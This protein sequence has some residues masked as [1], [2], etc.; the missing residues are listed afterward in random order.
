MWSPIH[1]NCRAF[2]SFLYS[3][4]APLLP[5]RPVLH[6]QHKEQSP[7][8][9]L[10]RLFHH[11]SPSCK[12]GLG[13]IDCAL[14]VC[15]CVCV[16]LQ[17]PGNSEYNTATEDRKW[18]GE[19]GRRTSSEPAQR[20]FDSSSPVNAINWLKQSKIKPVRKTFWDWKNCDGVCVCMCEQ[21][22]CMCVCIPLLFRS[23]ERSHG[24]SAGKIGRAHV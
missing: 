7:S 5:Q 22:P 23:T 12:V 16:V 2:T 24:S 19:R 4:L 6:M 8:L 10:L 11:L 15:V 3:P 18:N 9:C 1:L 21:V 13:L 14:R 20:G 17:V